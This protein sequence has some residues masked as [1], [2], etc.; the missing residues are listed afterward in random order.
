MAPGIELNVPVEPII[1]PGYAEAMA[2]AESSQPIGEFRPDPF[3]TEWIVGLR[4]HLR[5][6]NRVDRQTSD[7]LCRVVGT[8]SSHPVADYPGACAKNCFAR[9]S[10][11]HEVVYFFPSWFLET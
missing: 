5:V 1:D 7:S 10:P 11:N 3:Q 9:V 8:R 6:Q 4:W 2:L